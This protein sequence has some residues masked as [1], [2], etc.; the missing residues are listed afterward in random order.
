M[1]A[2][3]PQGDTRVRVAYTV[4]GDVFGGVER[5]LLTVLHHLDR[6][7]FEP[8]VLGRAVP[9]LRTELEDLGIEFVPLP[10]VM[11]KWDVRSWGRVLGVI[12]HLHPQIFHGMQ[13]HSFSGHY[14]L[15]AAI[16]RAYPGWS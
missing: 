2:R 10:E 16:W 7:R 6:V 1:A 9:A 14:A 13:S 3:E 5:H 15:A 8:V 4:E 11:S 12:R